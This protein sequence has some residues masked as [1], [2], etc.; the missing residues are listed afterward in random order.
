[1]KVEEAYMLGKDYALNGANT[2]NCNFKIFEREDLK[3]AW[4][5]G[6]DADK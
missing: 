2:N 6:R 4:E 1:M 5:A 3:L